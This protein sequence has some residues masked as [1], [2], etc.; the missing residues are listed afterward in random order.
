MTFKKLLLL[1]ILL[2]F[3]TTAHSTVGGPQF[4]EYL[5]VKEDIH[6]FLYSNS[7]QMANPP[8][9][10]MY[11]ITEDKIRVNKTWIDYPDES[12]N[13][14]L[15]RKDLIA[16]NFP[17]TIS[18]DHSF[19]FEYAD[20]EEVYLQS[21]DITFE[22][23]PLKIIWNGQNYLLKQCFDTKPFPEVMETINLKNPLK[24]FS[25]VRYQGVCFETGYLRDT[26]LIQE[27]SVLDTLKVPD[28]ESPIMAQE[29]GSISVRKQD[30]EIDRDSLYL[31]IALVILSSLMMIIIFIKKD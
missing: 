11:D 21:M 28:Q 1:E 14:A 8:E 5:G 16:L 23:F 25:I 26:L 4:L 15:A 9:L 29:D 10:W 3:F 12:I 30:V 17:D 7:D 18:F 6:Y 13:Q 20:P 19:I 22:Q 31:V 27:I 24:S 2:L